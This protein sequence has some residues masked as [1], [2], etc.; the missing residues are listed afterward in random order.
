MVIQYKLQIW[1][2]K[3][4]LIGHSDSAQHKQMSDW[5]LKHSTSHKQ[6]SDWSLTHSTSH[7]QMS[8]WSLIDSAPH[9]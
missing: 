5:S 1:D 2:I 7:K 6:M 8:D 9:K 3:R 4:Y